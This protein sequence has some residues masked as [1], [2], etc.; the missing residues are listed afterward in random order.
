MNSHLLHIGTDELP[1][2]AIPIAPELHRNFAGADIRH[3]G[4]PV[5]DTGHDLFFKRKAA[6]SGCLTS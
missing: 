3:R 1:H 4:I 6:S 5:V 2:N